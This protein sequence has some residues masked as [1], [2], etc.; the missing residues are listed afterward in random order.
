M[1]DAAFENHVVLS[2]VARIVQCEDGIPV[3][4]LVVVNAASVQFLEQHLF[5]DAHAR[6]EY[7]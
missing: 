5:F 1:V 3:V 6:I 4:E 2:P 7:A